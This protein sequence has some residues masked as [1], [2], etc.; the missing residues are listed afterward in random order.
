MTVT[1]QTVAAVLLGDNQNNIRLFHIARHLS[2]CTPRWRR[3]T[4]VYVRFSVGMN[5]M[6]VYAPLAAA[7]A[8]C[9]PTIRS[10][11]SNNGVPAAIM[12]I[13]KRKN[14]AIL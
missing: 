13:A 12:A 8:C 7:T 10:N 11:N 9:P 3:Y 5:L 6:A 14:F 4:P 1:P 2:H